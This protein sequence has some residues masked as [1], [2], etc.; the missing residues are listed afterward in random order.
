MLSTKKMIAEIQN[1]GLDEFLKNFGKT[2]MQQSEQEKTI[3]SREVTNIFFKISSLYY[4]G[5][6]IIKKYPRKP[7]ILAKILNGA[8]SENTSRSSEQLSFWLD[9]F[10]EDEN[11][12]QCL[13]EE[14]I[15]PLLLDHLKEAFQEIKTSRISFY[16]P[17]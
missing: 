1:N 13:W 10:E 16:S 8:I 14:D 2:L 17:S 5:S 7:E 3:I 11:W 6:G 9:A 15:E 12:S 4:E